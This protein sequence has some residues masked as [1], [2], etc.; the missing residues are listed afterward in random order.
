[1]KRTL[2]ISSKAQKDV[3]TFSLSKLW[4][5]VLAGLPVYFDNKD[6][7]ALNMSTG[8]RRDKVLLLPST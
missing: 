1:M 7:C 2:S 4:T 8:R 6:K 3:S 5:D